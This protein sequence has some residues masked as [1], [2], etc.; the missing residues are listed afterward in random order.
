LKIVTFQ[1]KVKKANHILS[2]KKTHVS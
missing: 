2:N 1:R